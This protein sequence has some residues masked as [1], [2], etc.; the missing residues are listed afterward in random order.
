MNSEEETKKHIVEVAKLLS[1]ISSELLK[2]AESH[3]ASKL[4]SPEKE[5]FDK[6]NDLLSNVVYGS[7]EYDELRK[8][9]GPALIHHYSTNSHH[10]EF[11][12]LNG[13]CKTE[14]DSIGTMDL[15]DIVEML[16]D[17]KAASLRNKDGDIEKSLLINEKRFGINKQ[18]T[19][20][21]RNTVILL[22]YIEQNK[23]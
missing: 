14:K 13:Y 10:P 1:T 2:R 8:K 20:I 19:D 3:D 16:C 15:V 7:P 4:E 5:E 17:W 9:L 12:Y 22:K 23:S 11:Y 21:F 6:Y 18:L